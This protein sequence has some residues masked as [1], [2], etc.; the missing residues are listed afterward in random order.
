MVKINWTG[1]ATEDLTNIAEFIKKDSEKF[2][3]ITVR[4]IRDRAR[5]LKQLPTSGK[6][7]PEI[8]KTEIRE[9]IFGNY[10]IIYKI[11]STTRIDILTVHHSARQL[12]L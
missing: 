12:K 8:E 5:Q 10:R 2:A 11:F 7:V 1:Q 9:L 3:R 4:N 6:I